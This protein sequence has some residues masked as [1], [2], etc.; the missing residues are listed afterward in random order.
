MMFSTRVSLLLTCQLLAGQRYVHSFKAAPMQL[1]TSM[2]NMAVQAEAIAPPLPPPSLDPFGLDG[3]LDLP[4]QPLFTP[5]VVDAPKKKKGPGLQA[6]T[7]RLRTKEDSL[8]LHKISN[9]GFV[10]SSTALLGG[11]ICS[12]NDQ[13]QFLSQVPAWLEP[14]DTMFLVSSTVQAL[15]SIPMIKKFRNKDPEAAATQLAMGLT[16]I[17]MAA[18]ASWQGPFCPGILEDHW[19]PIFALLIGMIATYDYKSAF[20]NY[21]VIQSQMK[22]IGV[23]TQVQTWQEKINHWFCFNGQFVAG[24]VAN[25][26]FLAAMLNAPDREGLLQ[27]MQTGYNLPFCSGADLP[28]VYFTTVLA[29]TVISYQSLLATLANKKLMSPDTVTTFISVTSAGVGAGFIHN[30]FAHSLW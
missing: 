26:A 14:F 27:L 21:D 4:E 7:R 1:R 30:L 25:A 20:G 13:G 18:Y 11:M 16:S 17:Q 12:P 3:I 8:S 2:N 5:P 9:L 6:W 29:G 10:I 28:L 23:S 24:T 19:K 15:V 22:S